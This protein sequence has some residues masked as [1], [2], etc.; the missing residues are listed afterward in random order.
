MS[1]GSG[2]RLVENKVIV[3]L[4]TEYFFPPNG[5][6]PAPTPL[7]QPLSRS[8]GPYAARP[9]LPRSREPCGDNHLDLPAFTTPSRPSATARLHVGPLSTNAWWLYSVRKRPTATSSKSGLLTENP[10]R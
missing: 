7:T 2:H 1:L 6:R 4:K 3:V 10:E 9:A 8:S 5:A